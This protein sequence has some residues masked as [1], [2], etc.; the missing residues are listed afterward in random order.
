MFHHLISTFVQRLSVAGIVPYHP[1]EA[2]CKALNGRPA[3]FRERIIPLPRAFQRR[4]G[5]KDYRSER[6]RKK[7]RRRVSSHASAEIPT[8]HSVYKLGFWILSALLLIE[9]VYVERLTDQLPLP[10]PCVTGSH[11]QSP[12]DRCSLHSQ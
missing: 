6:Y 7:S 5:L 10:S 11:K 8:M 2:V 12:H 1:G 4:Q 3:V 9:I